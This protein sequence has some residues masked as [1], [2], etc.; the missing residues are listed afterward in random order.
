MVCCVR[1]GMAVDYMS[2]R[3]KDDTDLMIK[4]KHKTDRTQKT[5]DNF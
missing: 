1:R 3:Q 4:K 2:N 5:Q